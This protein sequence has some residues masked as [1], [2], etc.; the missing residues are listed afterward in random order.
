[1]VMVFVRTKPRLGPTSHCKCHPHTPHQSSRETAKV[2][3]LCLTGGQSVLRAPWALP[4]ALPSSC[5]WVI[6]VSIVLWGG[7]GELCK[8]LRS[9]LW[10]PDRAWNTKSAEGFASDGST[11]NPSQDSRVQIQ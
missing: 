1:M 11:A 3:K 9:P 4:A 2:Y 10:C 5:R 8:P 7:A 6:L